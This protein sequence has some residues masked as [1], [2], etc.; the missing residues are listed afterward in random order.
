MTNH[1]N[2]DTRQAPG[3][4]LSGPQDGLKGGSGMRE[5]PEVENEAQAGADSLGLQEL[6]THTLTHTSTWDAM[7][8]AVDAAVA[9]EQR[10]RRAEAKLARVQRLVDEYPAGIDTALLEE[11]L[12]DPQPAHDAG[13]SVRECAAAD[14]RW[15]DSEKTGER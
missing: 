4:A 8:R 10:A 6:I 15:W 5:E 9:A 13:P 12:D 11:A 2:P 1:T 7:A 14:R 3:N